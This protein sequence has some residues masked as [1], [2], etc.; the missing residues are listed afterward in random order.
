MEKTKMNHIKLNEA[1]K[2]LLKIV[3]LVLYF[4]NEGKISARN[5]EKLKYLLYFANLDHFEKH[6]RPIIKVQFYKGKKDFEI[7]LK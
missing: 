5:F 3:S 2:D 7:R 6:Y 1:N 4:I